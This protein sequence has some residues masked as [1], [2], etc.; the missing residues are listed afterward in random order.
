MCSNYKLDRT[1][2]C[3]IKSNYT[4]RLQTERWHTKVYY[5]KRENRSDCIFTFIQMA[6]ETLS[7]TYTMF[8]HSLILVTIM[9]LKKYTGSFCKRVEVYE[10]Y[11]LK[12]VGLYSNATRRQHSYKFDHFLPQ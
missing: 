12:I 6:L 1:V 7:Q 4:F 11:D 3:E 8:R 9:K 2:L 10:T 5:W